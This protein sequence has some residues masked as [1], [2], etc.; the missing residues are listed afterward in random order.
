MKR[1]IKAIILI[2]VSLLF[3][4]LQSNV[5]FSGQC[6]LAG[7][8]GLFSLANAQANSG[9]LFNI[10][11]WIR[12]WENKTE[13]KNVKVTIYDLN[14]RRYTSR[15]TNNTG[16]VDIPFI[17]LGSYIVSVDDGN[18]TLSKQRINIEQ[19]G[20]FII[21]TW[22]YD[23]EI[24]LIDNDGNPLSNHTVSLY[25]QMFRTPLK[26]GVGN[27]TQT[28]FYLGHQNI[29]MGTERIYLNGSLTTNYNIDYV[30][31]KILFNSPPA[32]NT[33]ITAYYNYWDTI[34]NDVG[35]AEN[36]RVKTD[37]TGFLVRQVETD[38]NGTA[39]FSGLC[40]GTY[41]MKVVSKGIWVEEYVLGEYVKKYIEPATGECVISLNESSKIPLRGIRV[42]VGFKVQ[43]NSGFPIANATLLIRTPS[44]HLIFQGN[45]D[46]T[47]IIER[48]NLYV[49]ESAYTVSV[50]YG[51]RLIGQE[52]ISVTES[53]IYEI[54]CWAHNLEVTCLD[55]DGTPLK[56]HPV[57]LFDQTVFYA[58]ATYSIIT[59]KP[60]LLSGFA[61]TDAEGKAYFNDIWNGTYW[62]KILADETIGEK[63]INLQ[64]SESLTIICNKT[65]LALRF[66]TS[67]GEPLSGATVTVLSGGNIIFRDRTDEAGFIVRGDIYAGNYTVNAEWAGILVW[68]GTVDTLKNRYE[69]KQ[70]TVYRVTL[71][72]VDQFGNPMPEADLSF[73]KIVSRTLSQLVLSTETNENGRISVLLPYGT[74]EISCSSGIYEG[75]ITVNLNSD[76]ERTVACSI[77]A[78]SWFL[79]ILFTVPTFI[80]TVILERRRL[81]APLTIRKYRSM[82]NK[83]EAMYNSGL[84]EYKIYRK[85][86]D[87]YEMKITELEGREVG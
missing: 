82:L 31:G 72:F 81:R 59:E 45:T 87:E 16:H 44:G 2:S 8:K 55:L 52:S 42:D 26:V 48:K 56:D 9:Q 47:E 62:I 29:I 68:S 22:C 71:T 79:I 19:E 40:N 34:S 83:L 63:I 64:G 41:R 5:L 10:T 18:R 86:R 51:N 17:R 6:P 53:R 11:L 23:L 65:Y 4:N 13:L 21:N 30:G 14:E 80:L 36:Y 20:I 77:K 66:V 67:S 38:E 46:K 54:K 25:N 61:R 69:T 74:Y 35:F 27:G 7:R 32:E 15:V 39:H 50:L 76:F 78:S 70:C 73:R 85:L 37:E 49:F 43:S 12:D 84:V 58:P 1:V 3:L 60:G 28:E 57:L 33:E 75:S 24:T